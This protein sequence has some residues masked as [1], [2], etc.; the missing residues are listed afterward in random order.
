MKKTRLVV[1]ILVIIFLTLAVRN[2]MSGLMVT[3][4][5][6]AGRSVSIEESL[7]VLA[8][9]N[10]EAKEFVENYANREDYLNQIIDLSEEVRAGEVP[11]LLQWDMRW[12][13]EKFGNDIIALSGCGPVCLSMAYIY[14]TG[15]TEGN[16]REMAAYTEEEGY[17][18]SSGTDWG[19]WTEGVQKLGLVGEELALD[20]GRMQEALR[21]GA[22]IVCSMRPGDFTTT[23]HYIL[24]KGWDEDGFV[25]NDPNSVENSRKQWL[26]KDIQYQIK[27]LWKISGPSEK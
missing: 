14:L 5:P 8:E 9:N 7:E 12:G 19:L 10:R 25:V 27:N 24:L 13:Y 23:G 2:F 15:D 11:H 17:L 3:G 6:G 16:P 18:T 22:V 21:E 1:G 20:E 4:T 26:F